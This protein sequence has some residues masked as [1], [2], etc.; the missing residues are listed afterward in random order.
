MTKPLAWSRAI[1]DAEPAFTRT[2]LVVLWSLSH[3]LS[4]ETGFASVSRLAT[5][6]RT[7]QSTVRRVLALAQK[8][9]YLLRTRRGHRLG[10]GKAVASE[11]R[12]IMPEPQPLTP[13]HLRPVSTAQNGHLNRSESNLNRS[14]D[15]HPRVLSSR[16]KHQEAVR[17]LANG[18]TLDS[19]ERSSS[20]GVD[21]ALMNGQPQRH[22]Y[23]ADTWD[24]SCVHCQL[25]PNHPCHAHR[26]TARL[27]ENR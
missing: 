26:M 7:G 13:E 11:W 23:E 12:L 18:W 17:A 9:G 1:R 14:P 27:P 19:D 20:A 24:Q 22:N 4:T 21:L 3:R 6:S 8:R 5:D 16:S 15:E 2:Q 10:D 25:P